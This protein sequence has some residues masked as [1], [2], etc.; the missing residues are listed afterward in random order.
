M[1]KIHNYI[2][3]INKENRKA[4]NIFLTAGFPEKENFTELAC[5]V[6][7]AGADILEIGVPFSDPLADG[8]IIQKSSKAALDNHITLNDSLRYVSEIREQRDN[9]LILMGY[10]NPIIK[11]GLSKF[12]ADAESAGVNGL[13]IP[14]VP[15]EEN[16]NFF[17]EL[18]PE[19]D[20]ILLT[21]PTSSDERIKTIDEKSS[22]F[23]YCVSVT[24]TTGTREVFD[25]EIKKNL[26]RTK[27]LVAK[28]KLLVGFGISKP[29]NVSD[30]YD[31]ADGFI[32]GS[33]VIKYLLDNNKKSALDL[34]RSLRN[35]C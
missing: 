14:D 24:G 19:I 26:I 7:D 25:E 30:L 18:N 11:Y 16:D 32:V 12:L 31:T 10:A 9:P 5:S 35:V 29:Q 28:N 6:L 17:N 34:V 22:G 20:T 13:I 3:A 33:A 23:V 21:T 15:L 1:S 27:S 2:D 8:P 4:L